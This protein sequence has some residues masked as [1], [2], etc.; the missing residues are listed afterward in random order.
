MHE[1]LHAASEDLCC[2]MHAMV[3]LRLG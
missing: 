1:C 3:S 2:T